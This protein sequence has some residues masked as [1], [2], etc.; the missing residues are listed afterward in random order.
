MEA[1]AGDDRPPPPDRP[2]V[3]VNMIGS[4]DGATALDGLSGGL[5]GS[6]D[7][8]VFRALRAL[9][10]VILVGAATVRAERYGPPKPSA[11][12]RARRTAQGRVPAPRLAVLSSRLDLD[13]AEGLFADAEQPPLVYTVGDAV[14][15]E[16]ARLAPVAEVVHQPGPS[17]DLDAVLRDLRGRGAQLVVC[18]GGPSVNGQLVAAGLVDEWCTSVAPMLA[19]G[20]SARVAH[21]PVPDGPR[22]LR[23]RRVLA[24]DD[25]YLFLRYTARS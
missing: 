12:V 20:S 5:G 18:E 14:R 22:P 9:P 16:A 8:A 10:D 6:G 3:A 21:G 11:D 15:A 4:V 24:D 23:L 1:Y 7:K 25:G 13:P 17:V 19:G 2:W